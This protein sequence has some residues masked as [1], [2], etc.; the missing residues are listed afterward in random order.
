MD[1]FMFL[2]HHTFQ[3]KAHNVNID[4]EPCNTSIVKVKIGKE[5]SYSV[6]VDFDG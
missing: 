5:N 1:L 2:E 4:L 6:I 3:K